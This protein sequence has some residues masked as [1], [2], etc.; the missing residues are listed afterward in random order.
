MLKKSLIAFA[1]FSAGQFYQCIRI[2]QIANTL[3]ERDG[4]RPIVAKPDAWNQYGLVFVAPDEN[5]S[6]FTYRP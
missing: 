1:I 4:H 5:T 3:A 2:N 6:E